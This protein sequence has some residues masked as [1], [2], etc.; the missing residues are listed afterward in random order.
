MACKW[1]AAMSNLKRDSSTISSISLALPAANC[2]FISSA[3]MLTNCFGARS[4]SCVAKL[5]I[6]TANLPF[7]SK[8]LFTG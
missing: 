3:R 2:S 7:A 5:N 8:P 4:K 6:D 1:F